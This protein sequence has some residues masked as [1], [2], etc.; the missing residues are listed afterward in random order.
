MS[1]ELSGNSP[2]ALTAGI[3]LLSRARQFGQRLS[4]SVMGDP[5]QITPVEGP[6]LV[7]SAVLASCGVGTRPGGGAVVVVPGP[8]EAPLAV[9]LAEHGTGTWFTVDRSGRGEDAATQALVRMCRSSHRQGRRLARELLQG[10][11]GLGCMAEPAVLDLMLRAPISPYHRVV[12]GL[13]AGQSLRRGQRSPVHGFLEPASGGG[14]VPLP[15]TFTLESAR[16]ALSSGTLGA[17]LVRVKEEVRPVL[18]SWIAGML[19]HADTDPD[20]AEVVCTVLHTLGPVLTMPAGAVLPSLDAASDGVANA[21]PTAIGA[22]GGASD[23]ARCLVDTFR[24]LGGNFVD[25]ARFPVVV[26]GDP[27]PEGR[28]AR[29]RW[30]CESTRSAADTADSLWRRVIDPVQ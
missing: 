21:L 19:R 25:Y 2:A 20:A 13:H 3:L 5:D 10:L 4:V 11:G 29:W 18:S 24:F 14:E 1:V 17:A 27:A 30:F 8:S 9:C 7:H 22:Q 16:E 28:L 15:E 12:L 23:A 6:A 26:P